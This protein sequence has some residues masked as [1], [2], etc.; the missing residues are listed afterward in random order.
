M[1]TRFPNG[2]FSPT[3]LVLSALL[4]LTPACGNDPAKPEFEAVG[5]IQGRVVYYDD[6][7]PARVLIRD[8]RPGTD[9][10][11]GGEW[12]A[13][14][15]EEGR[16]DLPVPEGLYGVRIDPGPAD[17]YNSAYISPRGY[18]SSFDPDSCGFVVDRDLPPVQIEA[19]FGRVALR[20]TPPFEDIRSWAIS[21]R[22]PTSDFTWSRSASRG[23]APDTEE[24]LF[25]L[26]RMPMVDFLV[27]VRTPFSESI[28]PPVYLGEVQTF[29][30]R[31]DA[32]ALETYEIVLPEPTW[33]EVRTTPIEGAPD[34]LFAHLR[35]GVALLTDSYWIDESMSLDPSRSMVT[36]RVPIFSQNPFRVAA[37]GNYSTIYAGGQGRE[38][39]TIFL[40]D[41]GNTIEV[42]IEVG[43]VSCRIFGGNNPSG[44]YHLLRLR[45]RSTGEDAAATRLFWVPDTETLEARILGPP[46]TFDL[47]LWADDLE[48][49]SPQQFD[50]PVEVRTGEV[51]TI[52]WTLS[53][54]ASLYGRLGRPWQNG[55]VLEIHELGGN[56]W[57]MIPELGPD[58]REF[59]VHHVPDGY[60]TLLHDRED[61]RVYY[62]DSR[63]Q[64][65]AEVIHVSGSQDIHGLVFQR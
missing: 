65:T 37:V 54:G 18:R 11:A 34:G 36:G 40:P 50:R 44:H 41:R 57:R 63:D 28:I 26:I 51:Q 4:F 6:A 49:V 5:R 55:D 12:W 1:R 58:Q 27:T 53:P 61:S 39:A 15:D 2:S 7:D 17:P 20:L 32:Q 42:D 13:D 62:P 22:T 56:Y 19:E 48:V 3:L 16:F 33:L 8:F 35:A 47:V 45:D 29:S 43:A 25:E 23:L 10:Y 9:D 59:A 52:E 30:V 14:V 31:P 46:G 38:E 64:S 24:I 21:L 60:M